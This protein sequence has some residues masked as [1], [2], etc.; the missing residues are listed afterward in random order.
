[1]TRALDELSSSSASRDRRLF[2][3]CLYAAVSAAA[4]SVSGGVARRSVAV[5]RVEQLRLLAAVAAAGAALAHRIISAA[6]SPVAVGPPRRSGQ[7]DVLPLGGGGA[8]R[9][10]GPV[11]VA[12][13]GPINHGRL[14]AS[15]CDAGR[16]ANR[17]RRVAV[18]LLIVRRRLGPAL[19]VRRLWPPTSAF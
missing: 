9:P 10:A 8:R 14:S 19:D 6:S 12:P 1:M 11:T 3:N 5:G 2:T 13:A 18:C 15:S 17:C 16:A 7:K 4:T